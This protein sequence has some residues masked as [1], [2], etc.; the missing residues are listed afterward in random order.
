MQFFDRLS[1]YIIVKKKMN[2]IHIKYI[3]SNRYDLDL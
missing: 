2:I 1:Y 3:N